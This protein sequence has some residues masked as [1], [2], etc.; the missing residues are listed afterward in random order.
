MNIPFGEISFARGPKG[1]LAPFFCD[2]YNGKD[3]RCEY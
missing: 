2:L 3:T 1:L